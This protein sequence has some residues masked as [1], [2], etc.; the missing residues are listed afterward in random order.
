MWFWAGVLVVLWHITGL[1]HA[2]QQ[3]GYEGNFQTQ[4]SQLPD[5]QK[6]SLRI[7]QITFSSDIPLSAGEFNHLVCIEPK[8]FITQKHVDRACRFLRMK[9]RF[10]TIAVDMSDVAGGKK[11][12]FT[13][14]AHWILKKLELAGIWFGKPRYAAL[15]QQQLGDAFDIHL[16]EESLKA[17]EKHLHGKGFFWV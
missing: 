13:L 4:L 3:E 5:D 16:H 12:H 17:I 9:K 11:L 1:L 10:R 2:E 15:Y 8:S 6:G 7:E 14:Q